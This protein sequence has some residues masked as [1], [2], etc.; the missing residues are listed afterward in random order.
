MG[1]AV[2]LSEQWFIAL[3][4]LYLDPRTSRLLEP[5]LR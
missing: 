3:I 4:I 2:N 1:M 5:Q